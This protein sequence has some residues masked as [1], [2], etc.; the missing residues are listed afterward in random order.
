M[1]SQVGMRKFMNWKTFI[2]KNEKT[3]EKEEKMSYI[4]ILLRKKRRILK[5]PTY[6][7]T[8]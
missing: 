3:K 5:Y 8:L 4:F 6:A 2:R 1:L 7:Y